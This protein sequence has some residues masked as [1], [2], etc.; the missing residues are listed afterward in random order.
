MQPVLPVLLGPRPDSAPVDPV[1]AV[2]DPLVVVEVD[3][4]GWDVLAVVVP[5][6]A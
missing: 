4:D 3:S 2:A 6:V 1:V 5:L